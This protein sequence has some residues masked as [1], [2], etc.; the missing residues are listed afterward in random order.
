MVTIV[1]DSDLPEYSRGFDFDGDGSDKI[2]E[3]TVDGE[4]AEFEYQ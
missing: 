2:E 3:L 1:V 4:K